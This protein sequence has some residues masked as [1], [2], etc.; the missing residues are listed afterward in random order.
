MYFWDLNK[1]N[2]STRIG[3]IGAGL[4]GSLL[5]IR[6]AQRG[7]DVSLIERR[8]DMR[9]TGAPEGRSINLAL[10]DRGI[11]ALLQAGMSQ[12]IDRET[13][14][15]RGRMIHSLGQEPGL[16]AYSGRSDE[17]INSISRSGLNMALMDKA[18]THSNLKLK[19]NCRCDKV[20][21]SSGKITF[22]DEVEQTVFVE[23]F[24]VIFGTDGAGSAVR[25]SMLSQSS[26][27]RF[28]F[29][30]QYLEQG[31]KELSIPPSVDSGWQLEKEAL[32]IWPRGSHMLIAL[33]NLD[34]SFTVTL[35]QDFNGEYGLD[36]MD[37][38]LKKARAYFEQ[39]FPDALALMPAFEHDFVTNPSSSLGTVKCFP[40][41]L[42]GKSLLL[43]DAAHAIV[44]FYGQGMNA[45]FEDVYVL[46]Q[47]LDKYGDNW[48]IVFDE[49][50]QMRKINTDAIADLAVD[51]FYEMRDYSG[52]PLFQKKS[53]L[54]KRLE[55][56]MPETYFSKYSM[57]TFREDMTYNEAMI[58]GRKQDE[59]LL[60]YCT[61]V[62][63]VNEVNLSHVLE[64]LSSNL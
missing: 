53:L 44:P 15:M 2:M 30:Q 35:F 54:E 1:T 25:N 51:N 64:F 62:K 17:Y 43:G 60:K 36:A 32:H 45:A 23:E 29:S 27:V 9:V 56:E 50:Q 42:N 46:D 7:Y 48:K 59:L 40:W 8:A 20:D 58:R 49:Y 22:F 26:T 38:D 41:H 28:N 37:R 21:F 13:I 55:K 11:Q 6:M 34:G 39:Y 52:D 5:A 18:E 31:Y 47:L 3:I 10:S 16:Y 61:E 63:D 14:P 24:D 33:P 19:F 4:C 57:V 12:V